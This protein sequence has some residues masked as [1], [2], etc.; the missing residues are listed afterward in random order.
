MGIAERKT[1][2]TK[3]SVKPAKLTVTW[4]ITTGQLT[5]LLPDGKRIIVRRLHPAPKWAEGERLY[6]YMGGIF[7]GLFGTRVLLYFVGTASTGQV[8]AMWKIRPRVQLLPPKEYRLEE[9]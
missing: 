8:A 1:E 7:G 5:F 2:V 4:K 9:G 3:R 6:G